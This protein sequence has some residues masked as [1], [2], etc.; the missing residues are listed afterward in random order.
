[1][2]VSRS[3]QT[4]ACGDDVAS[5]FLRPEQVAD[6]ANLSPQGPAGFVGRQVVGHDDL[7][8]SE[9]RGELALDVGVEAG[10]V[11]RT[12]EHPR[13]D[14]ATRAQACDEGLGVPL[15]RFAGK[16]LPGNEWPKGAWSMRRTP[17]GAQPVVLTRLVLS[18]V[19][20]I[21]RQAIA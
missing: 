2:R 3:V 19:S 9:R 16:P 5:A 20:S 12:V 4:S 6:F 18:D 21:A 14:Q 10:A 1:M 11:H 8:G 13:G 15:S 7:S 17:T